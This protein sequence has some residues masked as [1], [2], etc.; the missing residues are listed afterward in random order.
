[1]EIKALFD[2]RTSTLTYIVYDPDSRD[3]VV[4]DPV[5]DYDAASGATWRDSVEKVVAFLNE[6][7]LKLR[8]VLETHAHADH[9]SGSQLLREACPEHQLAIGERIREVQQAFRGVFALPESFPTDGSQF[10]RLLKDGDIVDAGSLRIET[11]FTPGHTPACVTYKIG[12]TLFTGDSLFMPDSGTG[13]CDFP[14]GSAR[15]LY[16]SIT[17]RIYSEPDST[18]IFVGHDYQPGG[19]ELRYE[20]TVGEQKRANVAL[21]GDTSEEEFVAFRQ[22]RDATLPAP[23]LL[24]QSVQVNIDAGRLPEPVNGVRFL[25]IPLD[26]FRPKAPQPPLSLDTCERVQPGGK[27]G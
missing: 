14:G 11:R 6:N 7:K 19:R 25:R 2:D 4:I 27:Q 20:T 5:L 8:Y 26:K 22:R 3:A 21:R 10:G 24:F 15:D 17:Q 23:K 12:D 9:L 16:H 1:M 18:R 13:R